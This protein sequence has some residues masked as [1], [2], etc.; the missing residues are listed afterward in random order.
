MGVPAGEGAKSLRCDF[1]LSAHS[2]RLFCPFASFTDLRC[3]AAR[4]VSAGSANVV[5]VISKSAFFSAFDIKEQQ[6]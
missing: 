6:L 3:S 1:R 2:L 4:P 5:T